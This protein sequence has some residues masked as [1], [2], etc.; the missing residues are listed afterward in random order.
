MTSPSWTGEA[1]VLSVAAA[2]DL[3]PL[4]WRPLSP[5]WRA[6]NVLTSALGLPSRGWIS[7]VRVGS[8][9][10]VSVP[11]DLSGEISADWKRRAAASGYDLWCSS[12]SGEY[13]GYI[14]PDRYY[15]EWENAKGGPAYE[16]AIMSWLGP[17]QEAFFTSLLQHMFHALADR[18]LAAE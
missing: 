15:A 18:R 17:R 1:E 14:S 6:S 16:T 11:G 5:R 12:F 9:L 2:F 10:F 7:M 4:Q 8:A 3:P 13:A